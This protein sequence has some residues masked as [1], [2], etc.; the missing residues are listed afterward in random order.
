M[1]SRGGSFVCH[2][3]LRTKLGIRRRF[4]CKICGRTFVRTFGTVYYRMRK[5][6]GAFDK[7]VEMQAEGI[8]LAAIARLQRVSPGTAARWVEKAAAQARRFEAVHL[9]VADPVELQLDE[10]KT[11]GA[12]RYEHT[13]VYNGIEVWSRVWA[14]SKVATRTLRSTLVFV[15]SMKAACPP[16]LV[17]PL[18]TS[19]QLK[20]YPEVVG[21]TFGPAAVHVQ[22][23]NRYR[24]GRIVR[25]RARLVHGPEWKYEAAL[26]R[27]EDSK[28]PNT[29]F[30][31]RLNL[32]VRRS[33]SYL[34]RRTSAP[35]R[36]PQRL[37]DAIDN[38][39]TF[40][41]F[42]RPHASLRLGSLKRTPAMMAGI[43][44]RP[45]KLRDI[46]GWVPPP[47]PGFV[48]LQPRHGS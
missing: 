5:P 17:P 25:T 8:P 16:G 39:R 38:L 3:R 14:S 28:R 4:L 23:E 29:A 32:F 1:A 37:A 46:L 41:N 20:Y 22:V 7:A 44:S 11:Y 47:E 40:Y 45:L 33:C 9:C 43:F 34:H 13:W 21:R 48:K 18:V 36:K 27:S 19:D 10:L 42:V 6:H 12:G 2:S 35:M 15:R 30:V 24:R 26:A 31:E